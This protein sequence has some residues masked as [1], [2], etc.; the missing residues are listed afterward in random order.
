MV[1]TKNRYCGHNGDKHT[2][3]CYEMGCCVHRNETK[4]ESAVHENVCLNEGHYGEELL[5]YGEEENMLSNNS[6]EEILVTTSESGDDAN[7]RPDDTNERPGQDQDWE[8]EDSEANNDSLSVYEYTN[9]K[10]RPHELC[11]ASHTSELYGSHSRRHKVEIDYNSEDDYRYGRLYRRDRS[12]R[13]AYVMPEEPM[14]VIYPGAK[15]KIMARQAGEEAHSEDEEG[16]YELEDNETSHVM[17]NSTDLTE[18]EYKDILVALDYEKLNDVIIGNA[19]HTMGKNQNVRK[20]TTY[21]NDAEKEPNNPYKLILYHQIV[22]KRFRVRG[23]NT[24]GL[25]L[26]RCEKDDMYNFTKIDRIRYKMVIIQ[27]L[28]NLN[29]L[30]APYQHKKIKSKNPMARIKKDLMDFFH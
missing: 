8:M 16:I 2:E 9:D 18:R 6:E 30:C 21:I 5:P 4:A 7:E 24:N 15:P 10:A 11:E 29:Y 23:I 14:D 17:Q 3:Q 19:Y 25:N 27:L 28:E 12:K 20:S 1:K 22:E 13:K 26:A